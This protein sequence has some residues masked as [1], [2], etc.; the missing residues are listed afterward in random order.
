MRCLS[1]LRRF[2]ALIAFIGDFMPGSGKLNRRVTI[3][4]VGWTKNEFNEDV[5]AWLPIMS[6]WAQRKD[7][8]DLVKTEILAAEQVGS[9]QL[10][11]FVIRSSSDARTVSPLDRISHDGRIWEI[12]GTKET[13]DGRARFIE[14]TAA[15]KNNGGGA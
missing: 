14:V 2:S 6:V 12:R 13:A 11:H 1:V 5:E 3:E 9:F 15:T 4:R 8:S 7:A 10:V